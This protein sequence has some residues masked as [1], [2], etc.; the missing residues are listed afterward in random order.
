MEIKRFIGE[1][2]DE[3]HDLKGNRHKKFYIVQELEFELGV[4]LNYEGEGKLKAGK[5]FLGISVAAEI[6]AGLS[7]ENIQKVKIKLKPKD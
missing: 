3:L 2:L 4:V 7:K 5:K 1:V 6:D